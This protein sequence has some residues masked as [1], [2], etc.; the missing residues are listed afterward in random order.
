MNY[1]GGKHKLLPQIEPLFPKD[2]EVFVDLFCGGLDVSLN[3]KSE[4][5]ICNDLEPHI[6]DFIQIFRSCQVQKFIIS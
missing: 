1:M 3:V 5:K 6:I 4:K 2:I